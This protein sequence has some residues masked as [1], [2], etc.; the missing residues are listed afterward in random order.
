MFCMVMLHLR[1]AENIDLAR[2]LS[3][4]EVSKLTARRKSWVMT[5]YLKYCWLTPI[6]P[7]SDISVVLY[8]EKE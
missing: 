2:G 7:A 3:E 6:L 8:H 4:V 1:I 5:P